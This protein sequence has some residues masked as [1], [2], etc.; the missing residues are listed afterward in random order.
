M[1]R[2][3]MA[4]IL[5]AGA[6]GVAQSPSP[7]TNNKF[8]PMVLT[9]SGQT[10]LL[11]ANGQQLTLSPALSTACSNNDV[12][13]LRCRAGGGTCGIGHSTASATGFDI[14]AAI[15]VIGQTL[16]VDYSCQP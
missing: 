11:G 14:S 12:M 9:A 3:L 7:Y 13:I 5:L 10:V 1:R 2:R 4:F 16:S 15:S 6:I 8:A